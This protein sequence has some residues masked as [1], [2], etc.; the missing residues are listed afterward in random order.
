MQVSITG[1]VSAS[2]ALASC[3]SLAA[4]PTVGGCQV[5]PSNNYWNAPID[6]L[7]VHASSSNWVA[8]IGNT[9]KLHA[10]WGNVLSDNYGIPFITVT[11]AQP[12]VPILAYSDPSINYS[13]ESDPGPYPIP[14]NAPIE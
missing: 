9:A 2:L 1:L 7:P 11:G 5:F 4:P 12:L 10:D 8:T 3:L 13:D 14:S 6:T